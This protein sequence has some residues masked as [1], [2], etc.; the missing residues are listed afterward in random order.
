MI[1][2]KDKKGL[3]T[4]KGQHCVWFNPEKGVWKIH[5]KM[6]SGDIRVNHCCYT[7]DGG[8]WLESPDGKRKAHYDLTEG[9]DVERVFDIRESFEKTDRIMIINPHFFRKSEFEYD[10][11]S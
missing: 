3:I 10:I 8:T 5:I 4:L 6:I 11:L 9:N 2:I 7:P 1:T